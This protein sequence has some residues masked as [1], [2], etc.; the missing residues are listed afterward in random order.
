MQY[1]LS[2]WE[3]SRATI[4]MVAYNGYFQE[5]NLTISNRDEYSWSLEREFNLLTVISENAISTWY[6]DIIFMPHGRMKVGKQSSISYLCTKEEW[7]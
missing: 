7:K 4:S 1:L 3:F 5:Y 6:V 2:T